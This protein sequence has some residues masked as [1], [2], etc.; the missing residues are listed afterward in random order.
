[1]SG[2]LRDFMATIAAGHILHLTA[3]GD[4]GVFAGRGFDPGD[5]DAA[6]AWVRNVNRR[7]NAYFTVNAPGAA[8]VEHKLDKS[9]IARLRAI[10]ADLDPD[11]A[12]EGQPA[13]A[14]DPAMT[15]Y[16]RERN[17]LLALAERL[18][19]TDYPPSFV[20]DSGSGIQALWLFDE[21]IEATAENKA[22]VEAL[23]KLIEAALGGDATT[24]NVDR[25]LRLPDSVNWPNAK[26]RAKGRASCRARLLHAGDERYAF[27][28][29]AAM[30]EAIECETAPELRKAGLLLARRRTKTER[31]EAAHV[32]V[33]SH[34]LDEARAR[35]IAA[36]I[37]R[38]T[39]AAEIWRGERR[40]SDRSA[41]H[42]AF[43]CALLRAE[44]FDGF[45]EDWADLTAAATVALDEK[46]GLPTDKV[47]RP[48]Y[49]PRTIGNALAFLGA[50]Q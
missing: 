22:T 16:A 10:W 46:L 21:A 18:P 24:S 47:R 27:C 35:R 17:R 39:V 2:T 30:A 38:S 42:F 3:I 28:D 44:I 34:H 37:R 7:G 31:V 29:L 50:D 41:R 49:L 23:G 32:V 5:L 48:D 12:I 43:I 19:E 8:C 15:G 11:E 36:V 9:H 33:T 1:M 26:K 14:D 6:E 20:I 25:V 4:H 40:Y 13:P 45:N